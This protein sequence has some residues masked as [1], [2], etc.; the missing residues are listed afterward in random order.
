MFIGTLTKF[1]T[2][3]LDSSG[4]TSAFRDEIDG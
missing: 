4:I 1:M 3:A 2:E